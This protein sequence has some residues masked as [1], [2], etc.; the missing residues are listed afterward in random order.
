MTAFRGRHRW[1]GRALPAAIA[2]AITLASCTGDADSA[3]AG[4]ENSPTTNSGIGDG[5]SAPAPALPSAERI[6]TVSA[7][8]DRFEYDGP[9]LSS[10]L[11]SD[12]NNQAFPPPLID[13]QSI[14]SGGVPPDAIPAIDDPKFVPIDLADFVKDDEGVVIVD[15]GGVVRAYPIQILIWHEIVNDSIA[16]V[17][18]TITYCPLCNSALA[19]DRR[20]GNRVLDFGTSGELYQSALVM[21][22]RQTESLWAHFTGQGLVGHYAGVELSPIPAQMLSFAQVK[23]DYPEA[24]VLTRETG[25]RRAYGTNPY[26]A[27]DEESSGPI[28]AF[29]EG[30]VDPRL[31]PKERVI[32][33]VLD[34]EAYAIRIA[35]PDS[36]SLVELAVAERDLV[37]FQQPGLSSALDRASVSTGRHVGQTGAFLARDAD[38]RNLT[39]TVDGGR[40]LDNETGTEWSLTG[41]AVSGELVGQQLEAVPQL[42]TF[43]FAWAAYHPDTEIVVAG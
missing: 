41:K 9:P 5:S 17:P 11:R 29:F 35:D 18:V 26:I 20:V 4:I 28:D 10:A 15:I 8:Y 1:W 30:E 33:V 43:W 21:Y 42:N 14:R 40:F 3:D 24:M 23:V 12:R 27:Y 32:G 37:I 34:D 7:V 2:L 16:D 13:P 22:D 19:F 25:T 36:T 38:G 31:A 6:N 39:F